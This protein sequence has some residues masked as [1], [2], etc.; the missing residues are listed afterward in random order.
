MPARQMVLHRIVDVFDRA[1]FFPVPVEE[2]VPAPV[3][4]ADDGVEMPVRAIGEVFSL[5]LE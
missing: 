5:G 2:F 4:V 3:Q 1:R